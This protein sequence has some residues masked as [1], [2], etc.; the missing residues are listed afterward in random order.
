MSTPN[1]P[2]FPV[3]RLTEQFL[4]DATIGTVILFT[5]MVLVAAFLGK[6][7]SNMAIGGPSKVLNSEYERISARRAGHASRISQYEILIEGRE[8]DLGH[9]NV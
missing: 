9:G 8:R 3:D 2:D 5:F 1:T 7:L 4:T 6:L